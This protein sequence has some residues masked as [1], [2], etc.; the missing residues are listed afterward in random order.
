[1][2]N[3]FYTNCSNLSNNST[4]GNSFFTFSFGAPGQLAN[5]F[6]HITPS[7]FLDPSPHPLLSLSFHNF[8]KFPPTNDTIPIMSF[9][10]NFL[11]SVQ[12][13][14]LFDPFINQFSLTQQQIFDFIY[15][16]KSSLLLLLAIFQFTCSLLETY[17]L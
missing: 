10:H 9:F 8:P 14:L 16:Y 4:K 15:D 17:F 5:H 1:M 7:E 13:H 2:S 3:G 12:E 11:V 6:S